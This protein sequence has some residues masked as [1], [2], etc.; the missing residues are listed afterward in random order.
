MAF[1]RSA[2]PA[3][4]LHPLLFF[5]VWIILDLIMNIIWL[6]FFVQVADDNVDNSLVIFM[7]ATFRIVLGIEQIWLLVELI[8]RINK[9]AKM[10]AD[11]NE[12]PLDIEKQSS[13]VRIGRVAV[14]ILNFA[15]VITIMVLCITVDAI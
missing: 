6:L 7:P 11:S 1:I 15:F 14:N 10:L 13:W 8:E 2:E 9:S 5:Y 4:G 3:Y 12:D